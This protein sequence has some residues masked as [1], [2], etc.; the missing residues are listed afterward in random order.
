MKFAEHTSGYVIYPSVGTEFD[1]CDEAYEY[2]NLYSWE[3][4]FGIRWGKKRWSK[5]RRK[6]NG[7][8][9][10]PYQLS[11]DFYC[12]CRGKPDGNVKTSSSKTGCKAMLRVHRTSDDGWIVVEHISEHNHPLSETCGEQKHW[13]SHHHLDKYTRDLV[14]MLR[15]NNIG[16][17]KLYTILG[18]FFG[19]MQN[20][21]ATKRCLK[22]LCQKINR[23]QAEDDIKKT[24]D[25][26]RELRKSDPGFLFSVDT[27]EDGRIKSLMWT[28]SRS[29]MQYEHFSD[30]VSFDTTFKT[31]LYD[32]PFGL[33]VG[34]NNHLQ[35]VLLGG[36]LMTDEKIDSFKWVFREF[37]S[38]MGGREPRTILTDQCRSMEVA[39]ADEWQNT[40]H[41]WCKWHVL[42]RVK[43]CLGT[44]YTSIREF[45]D[46][47]HLML[48]E[49]LTIENNAFLSQIYETREKW[50]KS[51]FKGVFCARMIS[52]QRSESA[53][54]MLKNILSPGCTLRQ[55]LDQYM[56]MQYIRDEDENYEERRNKLVSSGHRILFRIQCVRVKVHLY[57]KN[58]GSI[59]SACTQESEFYRATEVV[60]GKH[61]VAE[62]YDLNR[63]QRWCKGKYE[64]EVVER[65]GKYIYECGLFEHFGLPC[66]HI[67][68]VMISTGVQQIP[69]D[70]VLQ[71]WT[72]QARHL[73]PEELAQYRKDNPAL[74][75]QT[76][77]HSSLMLKALHLV[78]M[79]DS[80]A[81]SHTIAMQILDNGIESLHEVAKKKDGLG[82][83]HPQ[84][85]VQLPILDGDQMDN[86]PERAPKRKKERGRPSNKR[87]KAGH[88]KLTRRPR[89][90]S[91]CRSNKHTMQNCPDRDPATKKARRPPTCS[92]CGVNGHTV[93]RC[94][95]NQQRLAATEYMFL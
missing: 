39:L 70:M 53:N 4:G 6:N 15:E 76:Y 37:A 67:L 82:L 25:L 62:H 46:K 22:T 84:A 86:F 75:A 49:M 92:G 26:I 42:K 83:G 36:V 61:Y 55:F 80:N 65:G 35:T 95:V 77:R 64:V 41:R 90:C 66:S 47:F 2:Y 20:V 1:S 81:E 50:V 24:M 28:N 21:P 7:P 88:E 48:N 12:S 18:N 13:P 9:A 68:R 43:E 78:E 54:H 10:K 38:L 73:L 87:S 74:M 56:K 33:F 30:V 52:T 16:I 17:T 58:R 14:R 79:G 40:V 32:M 63:V 23:E 3:C 89:F 85:E 57:T 69:G 19:S 91:V 94:G 59:S 44:K 60:Q 51:Y 93:D 34:V 11:Q 5:N 45:R 71:R 8:E 29:R 31:N 27:D 72:K